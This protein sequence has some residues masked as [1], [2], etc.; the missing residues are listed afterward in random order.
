MGRKKKT[1][2]KEAVQDIAVAK[3]EKRIEDIRKKFSEV[4]QVKR[5]AM[6]QVKSADEEIQKL[7][8]AYEQLMTLKAELKGKDVTVVAPDTNKDEE[9]T[10]DTESEDD[11]TEEEIADKE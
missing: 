6:A 4:V 10:E 2:K 9:K 11:V 1:V 7:N 5:T 8:G 3:I